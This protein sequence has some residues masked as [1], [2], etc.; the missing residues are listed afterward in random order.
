M[1]RERHAGGADVGGI[2]V[3]L[4]HR[5]HAVLAVIIMDIELAVTQ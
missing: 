5:Q 1:E 4:R 2:G 3:D